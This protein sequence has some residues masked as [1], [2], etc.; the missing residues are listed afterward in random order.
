M[1]AIAFALWWLQPVMIPFVVAAFLALALMPLVDGLEVHARMPRTLAVCVALLLALALLV[2]A[3]TLTSSAVV[4]ISNS[5]G[6]YEKKLASLFNDA[7]E[8]IPLEWIGLKQLP[9]V[10]SGKGSTGCSGRG[11]EGWPATSG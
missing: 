10:D 2:A 1:V 8:L 4:Q 11:A 5:A 3:G 6:E 7:T 9:P